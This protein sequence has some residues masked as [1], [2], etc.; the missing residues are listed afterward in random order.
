MTRELYTGFYR[1]FKE[2]NTDDE[3]MVYYIID[4]C[5]DSETNEL[6]VYYQAM[7]G[8]MIRYV[9]EINMFSSVV[10]K[11]KYPNSNQEFRFEKMTKDEIDLWV[12]R[13]EDFI[14]ENSSI[15][16]IMSIP[17]HLLTMVNL[18]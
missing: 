3:E 4:I 9:R 11:E 18:N 2:I 5:K 12:K 14:N 1:H 17:E 15:K 8:D 6:K 7:Y 16:A 13:N 10:D